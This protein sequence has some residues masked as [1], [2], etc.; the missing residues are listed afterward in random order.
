MN[1]PVPPRA[2]DDI[3]ARVIDSTPHAIA[4]SYAPAMHAL[5]DEVHRLLRRAALAVD[6]GRGHVPRQ[7]G[8]RPTRCG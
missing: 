7:P 3:G 1:G 5:R 8:R 4:M 6:A 2:F